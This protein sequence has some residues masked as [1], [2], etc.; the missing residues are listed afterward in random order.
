M[1]KRF[2]VLSPRPKK[3][4]TTYW[5]RVGTAFEGEKGISILFDS[6]PMPDKEGRC[7]VALFEPREKKAADS[8][9]SQSGKNI[10]RAPVSEELNDEIP[11]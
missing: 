11:W 4:G 3:D 8:K 7:S 2:D 6:L 5:H 10:S 9:P 1:T